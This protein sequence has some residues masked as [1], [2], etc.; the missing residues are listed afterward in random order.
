MMQVSGGDT[1]ANVKREHFTL[2][3]NSKLKSII[4]E[5]NEIVRYHEDKDNAA[6][7]KKPKHGTSSS[8]AFL[9]PLQKSLE[10]FSDLVEDCKYFYSSDEN[11]EIKY[12]VWTT[13]DEREARRCWWISLM[14]MRVNETYE[15]VDTS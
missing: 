8:K 6:P 3:I 11:S 9:T 14:D 5:G 10:T 1:H 7:C 2:H 15:V 4:S 13:V 12:E